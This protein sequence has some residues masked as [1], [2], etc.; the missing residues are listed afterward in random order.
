MTALPAICMA[1]ATGSNPPP[2]ASIT[3]RTVKEPGPS[4]EK[5]ISMLR[6]KCFPP[7]KI[8]FSIALTAS[9]LAFV[10]ALPAGK[11][12][13]RD[14]PARYRTWLTEEVN[15][16]ISNEEREAFLQIVKDDERDRFI[17]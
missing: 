14:L 3:Q 9:L 13:L 4:L 7:A 8:F 10:P 11:T 12:S 5:R 15:Y 1:M 6:S 16:I 2:S 17:E